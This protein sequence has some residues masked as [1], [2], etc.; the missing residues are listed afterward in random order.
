MT[1]SDPVIGREHER[2]VLDRFLRS[3]RPE[4]LAIYGRRRVGKTHLIRHY[5]EPRAELMVSVTG[6]K[7]APTR[8][9]LHHFNLELSRRFYG[10]APLP[11]LTSWDSALGLLCDALEQWLGDNPGGPVVVFLDELPWLA[12]PK[13][14]LMQALDRHWNTRLSRLPQVRLVV[15]GSAASWMLDRL[16]NAKGGLH[17]RITQRIRLEPF[18]LSE[19]REFL[20]ALGVQLSEHQVM[21]LY[22]ALGGVP[23]YLMRVEPG[24]SAAQNIAAICFSRDGILS[25]EFERLF[26][27]LFTNAAENERILRAI[28][29]KREGLLRNELL[30]ALGIGSGGHVGRRLRELEESGFIMAS[31]PYGNAR[32]GTTY[33]LI[34]EYSWFYLKWIEPAPQRLLRGDTLGYWTLKAQTPGYRA[35]AGYAFEGVCL[36]HARQIREAL[37]LA[38]VAT[39]TGTWRYVPPKNARTARGAQIDLLFDRADGVVTL[40]E[41]KY[42]SHAFRADRAFADAVKR[43]LAVF[44]RRAGLRKDLMVALVTPHGLEPNAWSEDL[45][46]QVVTA[47]DLFR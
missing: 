28:A 4:F 41:L 31:T 2:K 36:K 34:D 23:Y 27:S 46:Q 32:K 11:R 45:V 19:T 39:E 22:L 3:K 9:Q 15:C 10:G 33:R 25:D 38:G 26:S 42:R 29:R 14:R 30:Q 12:S 24:L 43:K 35:W 5:L 6:E 20:V 44:S 18:T 16:V 40:C 8:K 21:E 47:T 37:G 7:D 1:K 13:S 17:N